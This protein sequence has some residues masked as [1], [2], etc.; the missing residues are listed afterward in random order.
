MFGVSG[1]VE[2]GM[3]TQ[4][5]N[6]VCTS[7]HTALTDAVTATIM[8]AKSA[9]GRLYLSMYAAEYLDSM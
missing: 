4:I 9:Y 6:I 3:S 7:W 1:A 2:A 8:L 5:C